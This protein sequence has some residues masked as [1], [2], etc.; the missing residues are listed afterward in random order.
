MTFTHG[1]YVAFQQRTKGQKN[2]ENNGNN[3]FVGRF[4][5]MLFEIP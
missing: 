1:S 3:K 4:S 2:E 5:E